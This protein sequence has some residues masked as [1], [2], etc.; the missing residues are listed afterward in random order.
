MLLTS[1]VMTPSSEIGEDIE[2]PA[3]IIPENTNI[4]FPNINLNKHMKKNVVLIESIKI[5]AYLIDC[6]VFNI[7][8]K[9]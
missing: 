9:I 2:N 7:H 6:T 8:S 4:I 5:N 1:A 3:S